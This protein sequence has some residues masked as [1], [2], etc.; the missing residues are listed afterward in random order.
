MISVLYLALAA[1]ILIWLSFQVIK[2]RRS[3]KVKLGDGGNDALQ[4]AIGAHSNASEYMPLTMLLL[5]GLEYNGGHVLLV[6][7]AG[8]V[9]IVARVLHARALLNDDLK[10]RVLGMQLTFGVMAALIVLNVVYLPFAKLLG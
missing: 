1:I 7:M 8:V 10:N 2:L 5:L 6:H 4:G 3:N 9:F